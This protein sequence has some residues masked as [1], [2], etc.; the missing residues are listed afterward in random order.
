MLKSRWHGYEI[1]SSEAAYEVEIEEPEQLGSLVRKFVSSDYFIRSYYLL[2]EEPLIRLHEFITEQG[3]TEEELTARATKHLEKQIAKFEPDSHKASRIGVRA[4]EAILNYVGAHR[5]ELKEAETFR[6]ELTEYQKEMMED[7]GYDLEEPFEPGD[8]VIEEYFYSEE[9]IP[10][11]GVVLYLGCSL[12]PADKLTPKER[13][14]VY[15]RVKESYEMLGLL[16]MSAVWGEEPSDYVERDINQRHH[17]TLRV[18]LNPDTSFTIT[19]R[20]FDD[21]QFIFPYHNYLLQEAA[22]ETGIDLSTYTL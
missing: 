1:D 20:W 2:F 9:E 8:E 19:G 3:N 21:G 11:D 13:K 6:F 7:Y 14:T 15:N 4:L 16:D 17:L 5:K 12:V 18:R 22:T 10:L